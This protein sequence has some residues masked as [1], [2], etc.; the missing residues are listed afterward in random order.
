MNSLYSI[1]QWNITCDPQPSEFIQSNLKEQSRQKWLPCYAYR[2]PEVAMH[3]WYFLFGVLTPCTSFT[4]SALLKGYTYHKTFTVYPRI[5]T[6]EWRM[7]WRGWHTF[8]LLSPLKFLGAVKHPV[9]VPIG[10]SP[11]KGTRTCKTFMAYTV[12]MVQ[13]SQISKF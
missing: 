6:P 10:G 5:I 8:M 13:L 1:S 9:V 2:R 11:K 4:Q 3:G 7:R 12:N